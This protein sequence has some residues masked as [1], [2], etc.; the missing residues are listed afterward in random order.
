[1]LSVFKFNCLV[2]KRHFF[3]LQNH[4]N[5]LVLDWNIIFLNC[6]KK[7]L[8]FDWNFIAW[9]LC[10]QGFKHPYIINNIN[11]NPC[12]LFISNSA[13]QAPTETLFHSIIMGSIL[14][15]WHSEIRRG[16]GNKRLVINTNPH[17]RAEG[18]PRSGQDIAG[19]C[20]GRERLTGVSYPPLR[21]AT[22]SRGSGVSWDVEA[23]YPFIPP[24][25]LQEER[26]MSNRKEDKSLCL[27]SWCCGSQ[28]GN[29]WQRRRGERQKG[30]AGIRLKERLG[31]SRER[32]SE[33]K[34]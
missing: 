16:S 21:A 1:M 17:R 26:G 14:C 18:R 6:K 5:I 34:A 4:T 23:A 20:L 2:F 19:M 7:N 3:D 15:T 9:N 31:K 10:S 27:N 12:G 32:N 25:P 30:V 8:N 24:R 22:A 28:G 33:T 29:L 13:K 11:Q